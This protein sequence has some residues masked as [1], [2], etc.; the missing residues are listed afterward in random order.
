MNGSKAPVCLGRTFCTKEEFDASVNGF[1]AKALCCIVCIH[2]NGKWD[3]KVKFNRQS[4]A[5]F[6]F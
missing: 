3:A 5:H 1:G 6:A 4:N 2:M